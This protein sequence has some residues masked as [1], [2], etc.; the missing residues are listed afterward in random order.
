MVLAINLQ[1]AQTDAEGFV[2]LQGITYPAVRD[3]G[4]TAASFG[5]TGIPETYFLDAQGRIVAHVP[6]Q[7][8]G[9]L[10]EVLRL[11]AQGSNTRTIARE[12]GYSERTVKTLIHDIEVALGAQTRAQAV[13]EGLRLGLI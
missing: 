10:L 5:V 12:L 9:R 8:D 3:T 13:A 4:V 1:D 2:R 11:L 6:G 7:V